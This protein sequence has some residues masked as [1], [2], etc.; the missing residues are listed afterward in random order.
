MSHVTALLA[1]DWQRT[2]EWKVMSHTNERS[3]YT[4]MSHVTREEVMSHKNESCHALL[5]HVAREWVMSLLF[6]PTIDGEFDDW[7]V[8]SHMKEQSRHTWISHVANEQVMSHKNESLVNESCR[9]WMSH[10]TAI[11][12]DTWQQTDGWRVMSHTNKESPTSHMNESCH[13]RRSQVTQEWVMS[14]V[15]EACCTWISHVTARLADNLQQTDESGDVSRMNE[16]CH[17]WGSHGTQE[18]I[19]R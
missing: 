1:D 10:V 3:R 11:F 14:H 9:T 15:N 17:K 19:P 16:S 18:W 7:K 4:K 2:G 6:W 5:S 8:M 12:A 13:M